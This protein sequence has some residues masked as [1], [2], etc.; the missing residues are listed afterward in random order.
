MS[1]GTKL[2]PDVDGQL[3]SKSEEFCP[4]DAS[5]LLLVVSGVP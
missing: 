4:K 3:I 2:P 1:I 5:L